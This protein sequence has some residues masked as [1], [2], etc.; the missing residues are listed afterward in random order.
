MISLGG[1]EPLIQLDTNQASRPQQFSK[2]WRSFLFWFLFE[3][4]FLIM[5]YELYS[6]YIE[7]ISILNWI[8]LNF[9]T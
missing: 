6:L 1:K 9:T 7:L 4:L 5:T 2:P 8:Y 3:I